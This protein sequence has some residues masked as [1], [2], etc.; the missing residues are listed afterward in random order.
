ML[1]IN[2]KLNLTPQNW[3]VDDLLVVRYQIKQNIQENSL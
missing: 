2:F 1:E 3:S